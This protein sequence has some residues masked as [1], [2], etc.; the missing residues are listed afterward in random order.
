MQ[1]W[2][3]SRNNALFQ[4]HGL[5]DQLADRK[6]TLPEPVAAAVDTLNRI[7]GTAPK[8]PAQNAIRE[9]ILADRNA[10]HINSLLLAELAHQRHAAEHQN[11]KVDAALVVLAAVI[12]TRD[13]I[14]PQL[15]AQADMAIAHLTAAAKLSSQDV[16]QLVR[17]GDHKG[18]QLVAEVDTVAAELDTL[19]SLRDGYLYRGGYESLRVGPVD[20]SRWKNPDTPGR[21]TSVAA[22]FLDGLTRKNTL[23]FPTQGQAVEAAQPAYRREKAEAEQRERI[24]R[25]QNARARA[26]AG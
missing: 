10:D 5:L 26:F 7:E 1:P 12:D 8:P 25:E 19:Y 20:A 13:D 3:N 14:F 11:A 18:A 6:I 4:A 17:D 15:K 21:G 9:A 24:R 22:Q 16:M 2:K 23:W